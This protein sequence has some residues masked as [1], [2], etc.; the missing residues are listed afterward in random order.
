MTGLQ[1]GPGVTPCATLAL[2]AK[3]TL[4]HQDFRL[5]T[6]FVFSNPMALDTADRDTSMLRGTASRTSLSSGV[7]AWLPSIYGS[8]TVIELSRTSKQGETPDHSYKKDRMAIAVRSFQCN[9]S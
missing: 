8:I 2:G 3:I 4:F 9:A 6:V 5:R 1:C 7:R